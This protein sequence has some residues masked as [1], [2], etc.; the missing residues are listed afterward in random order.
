MQAIFYHPT[1]DFSLWQKAFTQSLDGLTLFDYQGNSN[2]SKCD[3]DF[4]FVWAPPID[5][6]TQFPNLK[7]V[8]VLGAGVDAILDEAQKH[9]GYIPEN[10]PLVRIEDGGMALQ[11]VEYALARVYHYFRR[12]DAYD[13]LKRKKKWNPL[14]A[15]SYEE[16]SI[17]ILGAGVLGKAV[18]T[19]L[20]NAGYRVKS[21][22]RSAQNTPGV[23]GFYGADKLD[24]FL[25]GTQL[26]INLL[27]STPETRGIINHSLLLKLN[28]GCYF[29]NL[30][31]GAHVIEEDLLALLDSDHIAGASL[32][33]FSK[34]PLDIEHLLWE[35]EKV[36]ITPHIAA[37]SSIK[38]TVSQI[39]Q[40][41]RAFNE[42][43]LMSGV[44]D[45]KKGY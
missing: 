23:E 39:S 18:A 40:N 33:V 16:F 25:Q 29:I 31:R 15:F 34:E 44:V 43:R 6:L 26:L 2:Y 32:D 35:N 11:M 36:F 3:I 28:K 42:G 41:I 19:A 38:E 1:A 8:F 20:V 30:A 9:P 12:F 24:H 27:P 14:D 22:S 7:A 21:F 4:A 45:R 13:A 10:A 17:G 37:K 5:M